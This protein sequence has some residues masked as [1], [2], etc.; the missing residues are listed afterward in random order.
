MTSQSTIPETQ[1][2]SSIVDSTSDHFCCAAGIDCK[3]P[4]L[5]YANSIH[6]CFFCQLTLHGP[7]G[8]PHDLDN[9]TYQ[10]CCQACKIK[11]FKQQV[12]TPSPAAHT[13]SLM[14]TAAVQ[15]H[16]AWPGYTVNFG[17]TQVGLEAPSL[18]SAAAVGHNAP[19]T[20][21]L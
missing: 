18:T 21:I 15:A 14:P 6:K 3:L 4:L 12:S 10:N 8:V 13:P 17:G 11:Y 20:S 7:C 9:I 1:D 5:G 19:N 16:L 2:S